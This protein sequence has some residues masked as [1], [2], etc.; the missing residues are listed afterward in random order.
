MGHWNVLSRARCT[1]H[2]NDFELIPTVWM[3][4]QHSIGVPTCHD[5]PRFVIIVFGEI[6]TRSRKSLTMIKQNWRFFWKKTPYGLIFK[7]FFQ[8]NAP[9]LRITSCVQI[10]WNLADRKSAKLCVLYLTKKTSARSPAVASVWIAPKICQGQP[11]TIYL[12]F[13][14]FHPN[15]FT[16][17]R[18]IAECVNI[19]QTHHKVFPI[20]GEASPSKDCQ[21]SVMV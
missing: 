4:S 13:P 17:G 15:P 7:K 16:S 2:G 12:E 21:F 11:Q 10:S 1:G 9:R 3:E 8:K 14:K 6:A 19:V 5:F 18:V 20:L